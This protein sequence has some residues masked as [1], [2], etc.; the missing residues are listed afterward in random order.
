ML[1]FNEMLKIGPL[2]SCNQMTYSQIRLS[3]RVRPSES[4][5]A[6]YPLMPISTSSN[7]YCFF[8][9]SNLHKTHPPTSEINRMTG[10]PLFVCLLAGKFDFADDAKGLTTFKPMEGRTKLWRLRKLAGE[11]PR[12]S[13]TLGRSDGFWFGERV[14]F[15]L[16]RECPL[17][18]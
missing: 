17:M 2:N 11:E 10:K 16:S 7:F 13:A 12:S 18:R 8:N 3:K 6:S 4:R 15:A 9:C 5:L 1:C 14:R